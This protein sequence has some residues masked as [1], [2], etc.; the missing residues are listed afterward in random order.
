MLIQAQVEE[1]IEYV[2]SSREGRRASFIK[3]A[4][5]MDFRVK[6]DVIQ[7]ALLREGFHRHLTMRKPPILETNRI[8]R[9]E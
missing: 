7:T 3:L 6:K 1:L 2:C 9:L 8:K 4:K 5:I